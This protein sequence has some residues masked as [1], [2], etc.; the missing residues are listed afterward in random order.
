MADMSRSRPELPT[1]VP[2]ISQSPGLADELMRE[3]A[4]FLAAEEV[5]TGGDVLDAPDL[6]TLQAAL[7]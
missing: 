6:G 5:R 2:Q 4:P 3:L 7:N 1:G